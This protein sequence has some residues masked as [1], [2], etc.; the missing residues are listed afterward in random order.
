MKAIRYR[1]AGQLDWLVLCS[2]VKTWDFLG[3]VSSEERC[4]SAT[5]ILSKMDVLCRSSFLRINDQES[6][7][8]KEIIDKTCVHVD[9]LSNML[10]AHIDIHEFDLFEEAFNIKCFIQQFIDQ[11]SG[12]IIIDISCMPKR[13]FFPIIKILLADRSVK[14]LVATNSLPK[15]YTD[16]ALAEDFRPIEEL[17]L[18]KGEPF[19]DSSDVAILS[20]GHMEMGLTECIVDY[21][22]RKQLCLFLPFPGAA[23]SYK[24]IW[25]FVHKISYELSFNQMSFQRTS[26]RDPSEAFDYLQMSTHN[27]SKN[28][29]LMPYGPKPIALSMC[30]YAINNLSPV[31]YTQPSVYHPDYSIGVLKQNN[32]PVVNSFCIRLNMNNYYMF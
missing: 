2:K 32:T 7:F 29:I 17:P 6:R 22:G 11:S 26:A 27:K 31:L 1:P 4:A 20:V 9:L 18:F 25:D 30:L 21:V 13:F 15:C 16:E 24:Y 23:Q 3:C 10:G 19:Q 28:A 5:Y 12:H 14:S 8:T